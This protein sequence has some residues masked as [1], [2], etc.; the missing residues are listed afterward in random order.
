MIFITHLLQ[1]SKHFNEIFKIHKVENNLMLFLECYG[2]YLGL[3]D[4]FHGTNKNF[5]K[6]KKGKSA[7]Q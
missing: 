4:Y 5:R 3:L 7:A 1:V 2:T 6:L